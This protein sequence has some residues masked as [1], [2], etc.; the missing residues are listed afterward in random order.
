[1]DVNYT[2]CVKG[3]KLK[4]K[5][6]ILGQRIKILS[7]GKI[8]KSS[9]LETLIYNIPIAGYEQSENKALFY[10]SK[11]ILKIYPCKKGLFTSI[12]WIYDFGTWHF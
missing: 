10:F 4:W 11:D 8:S 12:F 1:M 5:D 3:M 7:T 9:D 2:Q 6:I